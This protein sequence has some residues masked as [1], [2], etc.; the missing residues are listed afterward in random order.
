MEKEHKFINKT[1]EYRQFDDC[2]LYR[3]HCSCGVECGGWTPQDVEESYK[4]HIEDVT[5]KKG[6]KK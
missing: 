3:I 2:V 4:K 1:Q 6:D 5:V